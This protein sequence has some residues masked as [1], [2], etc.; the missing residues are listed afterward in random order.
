MLFRSSTAHAIATLAL[1]CSRAGTPPEIHFGW[2]D[3]NPLAAAIGFFLFGE[4]NVPWRVRELIR[5]A[6]PDPARQPEVFIG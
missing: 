3:E 5:K 4:G 6:E 1:E 2:S